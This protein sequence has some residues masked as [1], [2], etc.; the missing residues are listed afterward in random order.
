MLIVGHRGASAQWPEQSRAALDAA[1]EEGADGVE[2]DLRLTRDGHLLLQHDADFHR[3]CGDP[4]RV[5]ELDSGGRHALNCCRSRPDLPPEPPLLLEELLELAPR[6]TLLM[7]ELKEGPEQVA[8]L[9]AALA[10]RSARVLVISFQLDTLRELR[11]RE[12]NLPLLWLREWNRPPN[13]RTLAGWLRTAHR[14][15]LQGLDLDERCL[16]PEVCQAVSG[17]GLE[18]GAWTVD[19]PVRGQQL[20]SW[21]VTWLTTNQP[22]QLRRALSV[23][24]G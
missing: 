2:V 8:P 7:L 11:R 4:R 10:G 18:L 22:G 13:P 6:E 9:C 17:A 12:E 16:N 1:W 19:D 3:C 24:S 5:R 20:G 15:G 23:D 21:G 14:E